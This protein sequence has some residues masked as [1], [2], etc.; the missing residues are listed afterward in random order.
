MGRHAARA[1]VLLATA[2]IGETAGLMAKGPGLPGYSRAA[3][4]AEA[5]GGFRLAAI[6]EVRSVA[7]SAEGAFTIALAP[8][9][10]AMQSRV[11]PSP[12]D[13]T[14]GAV[15]VRPPTARHYAQHVD[16]GTVSKDINSVIESWVDVNADVSAIRAG[17]ALVG[18]TPGGEVSYT[19]HGR[20]Y[21]AHSNGTLYPMQGEGIHVLDRGAFKALGVYNR[22]GDTPRAA[23]ILDSMGI[24]A[25]ERAKALGVWRTH[26]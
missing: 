25:A 4:L 20:T 13:S 2:A 14:A 3:V 16:Q 26:S 22:F 8:G 9:A 6:G 21:G 15:N 1:F 11:G 17:R 7:V 19:V 5:Q 10:L 23:Q 12:G 18:R 24:G